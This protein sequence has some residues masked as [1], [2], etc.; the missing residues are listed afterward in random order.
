[1]PSVPPSPAPFYSDATIQLHHGGL[2][3]LLGEGIA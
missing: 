1:M 2:F 3:D